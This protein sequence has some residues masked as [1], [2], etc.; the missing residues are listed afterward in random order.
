VYSERRKRG[1]NLDSIARE[2]THLER[3]EPRLVD[4]YLERE[5]GSRAARPHG[6]LDRPLTRGELKELA[7]SELVTI[8]NHT[9]DHVVLT[10]VSVDQARDQLLAA[11]DYLTRL[12]G[13]ATEAVS[14]PEGGYDDAV[15]DVVR[16]IGF[17]YGFTTVRRK[18]RL[19]LSGSRLLELGRFQF[20]SAS[21]LSVQ[22]RMIRS[23]VQFANLARRAVDRN[24]R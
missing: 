24:R 4:S 7:D 12:T 17:K 8:G 3:Q 5:F 21:R 20:D 22:T 1:A 19:P 10:T 14:Y 23:E 2:I 13:T 9:A 18:D 11:S 16:E 6:D 15:L